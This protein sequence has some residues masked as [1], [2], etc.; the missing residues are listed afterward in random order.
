[1]TDDE[2]AA[3]RARKD[4]AYPFERGGYFDI[5]Y[6]K[7]GDRDTFML[8][9]ALVN[10]EETAQT[11]REFITHARTDIDTLL[12]EVERLRAENAELHKIIQATLPI[13]DPEQ[14]ADFDREFEEQQQ[15]IDHAGRGQRIAGAIRRG[16]IAPI[17]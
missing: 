17:R 15:R 2:L 3:I 14:I 4:A 8:A 10:T 6:C 1:M 5:E 16:K 12:A 9:G 7:V 13:V 11:D